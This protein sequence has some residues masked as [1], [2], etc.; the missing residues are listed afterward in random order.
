[1][2]NKQTKLSKDEYAELALKALEKAFPDYKIEPAGFGAN[3]VS[4]KDKNISIDVNLSFNYG[5]SQTVSSFKSVIESTREAISLMENM[6]N[7]EY[8]LSHI[9]VT[10][11]CKSAFDRYMAR[12]KHDGATKPNSPAKDTTLISMPS[13]VPDTVITLVID[14]SHIRSIV[15]SHTLKIMDLPIYD[16]ITRAVENNIRMLPDFGKAIETKKIDKYTI[17]VLFT[18]GMEVA[19]LLCAPTEL[20]KYIPSRSIAIAPTTD[21]LMYLPCPADISDSELADLYWRQ[22]DMAKTSITEEKVSKEVSGKPFIIN[23]DGTISPVIFK[24]MPEGTTGK[25]FVC[26]DNGTGKPDIGTAMGERF[27]TRR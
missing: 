13:T 7:K 1:M 21:F 17:T 26:T 2:V 5:V 22:S 8:L 3:L 24:C 23:V 27:D 10:V 16:V 4:M 15:S 19:Y 25:F 20:K 9:R 18:H 14:A 12:I 6:N 11:F